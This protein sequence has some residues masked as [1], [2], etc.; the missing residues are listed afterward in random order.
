MGRRDF[1][2]LKKKGKAGAKQESYIKTGG[3]FH[4]TFFAETELKNFLTLER[5]L[6][7]EE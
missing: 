7:L 1:T 2:N 4:K 5:Y 6:L 3:K